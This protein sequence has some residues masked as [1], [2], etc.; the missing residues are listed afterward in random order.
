MIQDEKALLLE[1]QNAC[2][3]DAKN[4]LNEVYGIFAHFK[5]KPTQT[6][7]TLLKLLHS[8]KG[9]FQAV[10]YLN[11][12]GLIHFLESALDQCVNAINK[13]TDELAK[14]N[15]IQ[16][17]GILFEIF[18]AV[19]R[20]LSELKLVQVDSQE[21][22]SKHQ[23]PFQRLFDWNP[24]CNENQKNTKSILENKKSLTIGQSQDAD[25][26]EEVNGAKQSVQ[27]EDENRSYLLFQNNNRYFAV[28]IDHV[29][30]ILKTRALN[31]PPVKKNRL[32]GL[33][34]LRGEALS[35]LNLL[36]DFS[37]FKSTPVYVVVA[38]IKDFRFG[39][40]VEAVC[41]VIQL[42][43]KNFQKV[44]HHEEESFVSCLCRCDD[45][46]VTVLDLEKVL[47]E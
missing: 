3:E 31:P 28:C 19:S 29:V 32:S 34:S 45:K 6:I 18:D 23:G 39:F 12:A 1:L 30:E 43:V 22:K 37:D 9:N 38:Q 13:N 20:Y 21:L 26:P 4:E 24:T 14:E 15:I 16:L 5:D 8:F 36:E 35:V 11:L 44:P 27:I 41:Q 7:E 17:E 46:T 40:R 10:G 33:L 2:L 42:N 47:L 25:V